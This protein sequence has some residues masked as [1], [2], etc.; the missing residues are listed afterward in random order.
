MTSKTFREAMNKFSAELYSICSQNDGNMFVSPYC[1]ASSLLLSDLA[2][3]GETDVQIRNV[4]GIASLSKEQLLIQYKSMNRI[5]LS[6]VFGNTTIAVANKIF[7]DTGQR[8][9][10]S[11]KTQAS[12][13]FNSGVKSL[14]FTGSPEVAREYINNWVKEETRGKISD[15]LGPDSIGPWSQII[16]TSAIYFKGHW[17]DVF[18]KD[19]TD[20][21]PFY[22]SKGL[23]VNVE[24]MNDVRL[25][26]PY[27]KDVVMKFSV[28][29][30]PYADSNLAM[31]IVLQDEIDGL[32]CIE[33]RVKDGLLVEVCTRLEHVNSVKVILK[34]PKFTLQTQYDLKEVLKTLGVKD[35]FNPATA[36]FSAMIQEKNQDTVNPHVSDFVHKTFLDVNEEGSEAAALSA[37]FMPIERDYRP[38]TPVVRFIADHPFVFFIKEA[39]TGTIL[40]QAESLIFVRYWT[41]VF[42]ISY[43]KCLELQDKGFT[44]RTCNMK[45]GGLQSKYI[46]FL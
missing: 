34:I 33:K 46:K 1:V 24:M 20:K 19:A 44:I 5:I 3:N 12:K 25:D 35:M 15:F 29:E 16:L 23:S 13:Y 21:A 43:P 7:T 17:K 32:S 36:D 31:V 30:L 10:D 26:V 42:C 18:D 9:D 6:G 45:H 41:G 4:F 40:F 22:T 14:D 11:F 28:I 2:A 39:T 37:M 38:P 8:V 27:V